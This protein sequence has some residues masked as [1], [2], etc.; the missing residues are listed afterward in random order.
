MS[1]RAILFYDMPMRTAEERKRYRIYRKLLIENSFYQ[2]QESVYI[3]SLKTKDSYKNLQQKLIAKSPEN[4]KIRLI[5]MTE[6]AF[7]GMEYLAGKPSIVEKIMS[8]HYRII[9]I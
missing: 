1:Y 4:A 5:L 2:L 6:K 7:D 9:E 8:S 3:K